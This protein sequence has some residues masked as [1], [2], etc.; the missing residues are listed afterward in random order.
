MFYGL[1]P[2]LVC[3]HFISDL[4][5][6]S[7]MMAYCTCVVMQGRREGGFRNPPCKF[8]LLKFH[9]RTLHYLVQFMWLNK[10]SD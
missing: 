8:R 1:T 10:M 6:G 2:V 3:V 9:C 5:K 7:M 4:A